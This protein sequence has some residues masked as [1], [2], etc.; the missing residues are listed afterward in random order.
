M[1][2]SLPDP[3]GAAQHQS[4]SEWCADYD[5]A[6]VER[7]QRE[8]QYRREKFKWY[9]LVRRTIL[10]HH[11]EKHVLRCL[12]DHVWA[13]PD[14]EDK[15]RADGECVILRRT[16]ERETGLAK[17]TIER[18]ISG[19]ESKRIIVREARGRSGGGRGANRY[20]ILPS[21]RYEVR[22]GDPY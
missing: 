13:G 22:P 15:G 11:A 21:N 4:N 17:R 18:A 16:I 9:H 14:I 8:R 2:K 5:V 10:E 20:R 7:E 12:G 6:T 19:L 1:M 3:R